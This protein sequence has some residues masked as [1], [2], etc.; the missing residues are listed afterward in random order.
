MAYLCELSAGHRIYLENQ[1]V[2]TR[3]RV[4]MASPGQQQQSSSSFQTGAWTAP[5]EAFLNGQRL[6][7]KL[8]TAE[9]ELYVQVQGT[10]MSLV[11]RGIGAEGARSVALQQSAFPD[12]A[13]AGQTPSMSSM[14]PMQP[15]EPMQPMQPMQPLEPMQPMQMGNMQ[16]NPMEMRM[17][18]LSMSMGAAQASEPSSPPASSPK[19]P[20]SQRKFCTQ[21]GGIVEA[22]DR[23]CSACGTAVRS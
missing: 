22:G 20:G 12:S 7:F 14:P 9:G 16:M 19:T 23:F 18:N 11:A 3:L 2:Q 17:G 21:C 13:K 6:V 15:M 4:S 8:T 5:P 1:G 10:S